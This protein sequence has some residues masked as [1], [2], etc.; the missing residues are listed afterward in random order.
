MQQKK[1]IEERRIV[2]LVNDDIKDQIRALEEK[3]NIDHATQAKQEEIEK[4]LKDHYER[5]SRE[6]D[7]ALQE[8]LKHRN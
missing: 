8:A 3:F 2:K 4:R 1:Q 7:S 6:L 5:A